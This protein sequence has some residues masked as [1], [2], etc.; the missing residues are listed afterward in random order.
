MTEKTTA[1][2]VELKVTEIEEVKGLIDLLGKHQ[3]DL[4]EEIVEYCLKNFGGEE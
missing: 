3:D 2:T 4:P 1:L